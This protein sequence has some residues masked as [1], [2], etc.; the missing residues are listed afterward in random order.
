LKIA[1]ASIRAKD[2]ERSIKFYRDILGLKLVRRVEIPENNAE[3]AFLEGEEEGARIEL[4]HYRNQK[5]YVVPEYEK[6]VFDHI[7]LVID[8]MDETIEHLRRNK[9]RIT[10]EPFTLKATGAKIAF[11][12]DPDG[13][14]LEL[15]ERR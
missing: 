15:I 2:M 9:V 8:D 5:E 6:A 3:I 4:T 13:T 14:L 1:H 11:I 7:A 10:D 12:E